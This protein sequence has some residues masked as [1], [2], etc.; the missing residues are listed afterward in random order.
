[1]DGADVVAVAGSIH[2]LRG[3]STKHTK[4]SP[5][6]VCSIVVLSQRKSQRS[7]SSF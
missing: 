3:T 7:S 6:I 5:M 4:D 2:L 1:M